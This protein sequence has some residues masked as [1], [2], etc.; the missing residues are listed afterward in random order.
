MWKLKHNFLV[1]C[2]FSAALSGLGGLGLAGEEQPL[3]TPPPPPAENPAAVP[4]E[5]PAQASSLDMDWVIDDN[6]RRDPFTFTKNVAVIDAATPAVGTEDN[7][8]PGLQPEVL[9]KIKSDAELACNL[10]ENALMDLDPATAITKCDQGMEAF[11]PIPNMSLYPELEIVKGRILR[12]RKASETLRSRQVAQRDFDA[13]NIKILGAVVKNKNSQV[14][15]QSGKDAEVL[16]KGSMVKV[17]SDAADVMVDEILSDKVV[18]NYKGFR[19]ML[20]ME[21][22]GK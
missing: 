14:I 11:K 7:D 16:H 5:K 8:R 13:M 17:S 20:L 4:T 19:M 6:N 15:I 2:L 22:S 9:A 18:F 1:G 12:A 3:V 21:S 10:A